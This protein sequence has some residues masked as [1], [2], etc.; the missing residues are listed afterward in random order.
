MA[1]VTTPTQEPTVVSEQTAKAVTLPPWFERLWSDARIR[2]GAIAVVVIAV[3]IGAYALWRSA[4]HDREE[5]ASLALSRVL[6]YLEA[7]QY[8]AALDGDPKKTVRGEPVQG[9]RAIADTYGGTAAGRTAALYAGQIYLDRKQYS[10]AERYFEQAEASDAV[11]V[12][13]GALAGLAACKEQQR[14]FEEAAALYERILPDAENIG[15][16]DKYMLFAA[17]CLEKAGKTDRAV[18]MYKSLLAEF[19]FSE[20][21]ADAK[22]GLARLGTVVEY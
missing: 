9:L 8:D 11:L 1:D 21:A 18:Q 20:Y 2:Y 6:P 22:A 13:I 15:F 17:L 7:Q 3:A 16:K 10:E 4:Q 5:E 19:E 12:R 14:Q